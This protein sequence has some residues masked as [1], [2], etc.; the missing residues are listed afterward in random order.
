MSLG[1]YFLFLVTQVAGVSLSSPE[2]RPFPVFYPIPPTMGKSLADEGR[3]PAG[4]ISPH[5][6]VRPALI[7]EGERGSHFRLL[8]SSL[9]KPT[10]HGCCVLV[11]SFATIE[12]DAYE[13]LFATACP[14]ECRP[15]QVLVH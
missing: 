12:I 6:L 1:I 8:E 10:P 14:Q 11:H 9:V 5:L 2:W 15:A 3:F 7:K 4:F 13:S